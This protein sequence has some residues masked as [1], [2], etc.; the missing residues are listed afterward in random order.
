MRHPLLLC[1]L[2]PIALSSVPAAAAQR[3][4]VA[5][6]GSDSATCALLAPCRS[7]TAALGMTD[8]GGEVVVLDSAGYGPTT[9]S[10]SASIVAP[11][12]VYAGI[13]VFSGSGI[14][15]DG[16]SAKVKLAGLVINGQGG[17]HGV[18][19][20]Q[21]SSLLLESVKI[22]RLTGNGIS[23]EGAFDS[24]VVRD[25]SIDECASNGVSIDAPGTASFSRVNLARNHNGLAVTGSATVS[26][27]ESEV[28]R[29]G[30]DGIVAFAS[31]GHTVQL[32]VSRSIVSSG[33]ASGILANSVGGGGIAHVAIVDTTV[34]DNSTG[35]A[36]ANAAAGG[37]TTLTIQRS[38]V[39]RSGAGIQVDGAT[40]IAQGTAVTRN[41]VGISISAGTVRSAGDNVVDSNGTNLQG[42][43]VTPAVVM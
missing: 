18:R 1:A 25:S 42:G 26:M 38:L 34:T 17:A 31:L 41:A 27:D 13:S 6:T 30:V 33:G 37:A 12:G 15:V 23:M 32:T 3:T 10:Q 11:P 40:V 7:F 24:L 20:L 9:I 2:V 35:G 36:V 28:T 21:G 5:S 14:V 19:F 29:S 16:P 8:A 43:A 4:F 39:T 22:S